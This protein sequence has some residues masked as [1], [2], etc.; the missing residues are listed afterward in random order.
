MSETALHTDVA[1]V[2]AGF[3][4]LAAARAL[5]AAGLDTLVLE[6]RDRTGG[7]AHT[8]RLAD[9]TS[10]DLGGQWIGP[11]QDALYELCAE[12]GIETYPLP[13]HG[14]PVYR[15][16]DTVTG[17]LPGG[18]QDLLDRVDALAVDLDTTAPWDH[19]E[20]ATLDAQTLRHWLTLQ[21]VGSDDEKDLVGRMLAGGLQTVT[22]SE[23]SML[24]LAFYLRSGGG[25]ARLLDA[26]GGAQ[27]DRI[28][29][30]P[31]A[32]TDAMAAALPAGTVR[33]SEPVRT[34]DRTDAE[35][36]VLTTASG[37][38]VARHVVVA[39]PAALVPSMLDIVPALPVPK[40]IALGRL[41]SGIAL[42]TNLVYD[43]PFWR[44]QGLSGQS[45]HSR[46]VVTETADGTT[47]DAVGGV[48]TAFSYGED[49]IALRRTDAEN[50][51]ELIARALVPTFGDDVLNYREVAATDWATETFT[52]GC[53]SAGFGPG[54]LSVVGR[55]LRGAVGPIHFAGTEYAHVW[56]GYFE[57][58][59]RSGR[60][61]AAAILAER[62]G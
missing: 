16:G 37:T 28:V 36:I 58:A 53:F 44:E 47:P 26:E 39:V 14:A 49:A 42:K 12:F 55:D 11:T 35:R 33:F 41:Q 51:A 20:A 30:G 7:R 5:H 8:R 38:V 31:Q 52:G 43:R 25:V 19:P 9:G 6:A 56:N 17:D 4:G 27:Q 34:I 40:R 13:A 15:V 61:A 1:A 54:A 50:R 59:V 57:G 10:V 24:A 23:T 45:N 48:L 46:G 60:S 3:A 32:V 62:R 29:G 22:A 18:V 2:G 21:D